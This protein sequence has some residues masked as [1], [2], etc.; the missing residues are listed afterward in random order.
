MFS[1]HAFAASN[2][3]L[4]ILTRLFISGCLTIEEINNSLP[5]ANRFV[6]ATTFGAKMSLFGFSQFLP[7]SSPSPTFFNKSLSIKLNCLEIS[8]GFQRR[9][10]SILKSI[11]FGK[12]GSSGIL[13]SPKLHLTFFSSSSILPNNCKIALQLAFV[14]LSVVVDSF[15]LSKN[16]CSIV[17]KFLLSR[18]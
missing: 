15:K 11:S 7:R 12:R 17:F 1:Q 5:L 14:K 13:K 8:I 4:M 6:I 18:K 9:R 10:G 2:N 16:L 3:V